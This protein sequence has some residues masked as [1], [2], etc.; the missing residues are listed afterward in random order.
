MQCE[1]MHSDDMHSEDMQ[2]ED[3]QAASILGEITRPRLPIGVAVI[4][5]GDV[6][7]GRYLPYLTSGSPFVRVVAC[8]DRDRERADATAERFGLESIPVEDVFTHPGVDLILNLTRPLAHF[9]INRRTLESGKHVYTEKPLAATFKEGRRLVDLARITGRRIA[10]APDTFLGPSLELTRRLIDD[11]TIG[12]PFMASMSFV[13]PDRHWHPD[14]E[15]FYMPGGGPVFDEGPYFLTALVALL[16]PIAE[17]AAFSHSY[18]RD[19]VVGSGPRAG[20]RFRAEVPTSYT[21]ALRLES[22]VLVSL[23]LSFDVPGTTLPPLE[24]YGERGTLRPAF[25]GHY[26]GSV[27]FGREH[28]LITEELDAG[29]HAGAEEARGIGLEEFAA[30][31][32]AGRASR[33]EAPL[34][35]HVLEVMEGI[36]AAAETKETVRITTRVDRPTPYDPRENPRNLIRESG[37]PESDDVTTRGRG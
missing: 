13:T 3:M 22:G 30:A 37:R 25:P 26:N 11:G 16:G 36:A 17:V 5:C 10:S 1:D 29:W 18:K 35:L 6:A 24:I 19:L 4:G 27:R 21:G 34:A 12:R 32:C 2:S 14:P 20:S 15:F 8:A 33:V 28:G 31:L 9:E 7:N 23:L